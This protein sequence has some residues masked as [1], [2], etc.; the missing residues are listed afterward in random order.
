MSSSVTPGSS[1]ATN[2]E[3]F[4]VWFTTQSDV[5]KSVGCHRVTI[6]KNCLNNFFK[7][8]CKISLFYIEHFL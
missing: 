7:T 8:N 3:M 4:P 5:K 2:G 6:F 1:F